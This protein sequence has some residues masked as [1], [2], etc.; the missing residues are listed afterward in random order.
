MDLQRLADTLANAVRTGNPVPPLTDDVDLSIDQAYEL[1]DAVLELHDPGGIRDVV[2]LGL[3]SRAKQEQMSVDEPLYGVFASGSALDIGEPLVT[4]ALIQPR[5]EPEIAFL[6][7]RDLDGSDTTAAHVLAAT[8]ALMPAIDVLDSRFAGYRFTL[9]DVVA[10]NAS[11]SRYLLGAPLPVPS[12]DLATLGCVFEGNG[13]VIDTAA[14][15]SVLGNPAV[16]VA[17]LVRKLASRGRVLPAGTV[18]LSG[19]LTAAVP[20]EAGD[21][22]R[23]T[24]GRLGSLELACT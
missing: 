12:V 20:A 4:S 3:T 5:V 23:L 10:D 16:A 24:I 14:G 15:G 13:S 6:I 18:V 19:A 22:F 1:Q 8:D 7:G 11:A 17:W 2:K 9:P 21:N